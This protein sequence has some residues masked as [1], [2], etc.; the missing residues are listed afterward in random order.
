METDK[1]PNASFSG[2][3]IEKIDF[4]SMGNYSIRAKGD[5]NIHGVKQE[6]IIKCK[7][8]LVKIDLLLI[9]IL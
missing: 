1:Y 7:F 8:T 9:Q 4:D 2:K 3:I 6:R 5:L